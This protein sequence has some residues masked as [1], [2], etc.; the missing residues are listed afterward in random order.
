MVDVQGKPEPE[1][2]AL[3]QP[4]KVKV[5]RSERFADGTVAGVVVG[6]NPQP[7][8]KVEEKSTVRLAI[9][10]GPTPVPVPDVSKIS[11]A[12]AK[13]KLSAAGLVAGTVANDYSE[14]VGE[15]TVLDYNP[16]GEQPKGT[17][18]A[19]SVSAGPRPRTIPNVTGKTYDQAAATL[20]Q[21]G[22]AAVRADAF[23]DTVLKD[24]VIGTTPG[25]G[26]SV[27]KGSKVTVTISK[28][29]DVVAVPNVKGKSVQQ[30][31]AA[32]QQ[33]GLG[34]SNVFGPPN[35]TVFDTDPTAGAQV[36]RGSSVNLYTK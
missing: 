27:D 17:A 28:G 25:A 22:L 2:M 33:A 5:V 19:M 10:K 11:L 29:P 36:K 8:T 12:S 20:A 13:E 24:Q 18:I 31:Q 7:R 32:L 34:V 30:A 16:K 15:G 4:L 3:L 21:V 14:T 26:A 35:K 23:S 6:Q 9:S 1:A